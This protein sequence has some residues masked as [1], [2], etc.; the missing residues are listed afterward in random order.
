M[1]VAFSITPLG[2][3][4]GVARVSQPGLTPAFLAAAGGPKDPQRVDRDRAAPF[5]L[6]RR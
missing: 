1:L 4:E 3:G 5:H 2:V 6:G